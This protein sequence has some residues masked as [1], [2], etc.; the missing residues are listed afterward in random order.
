[1][2]CWMDTLGGGDEGQTGWK[3]RRDR[4]G[5]TAR[6]GV[7]AWLRYAQVK[8]GVLAHPAR[9]QC[10]CFSLVG[11]IALTSCVAFPRT[12]FWGMKVPRPDS[13]AM[14]AMMAMARGSDDSSFM[15]RR[16]ATCTALDCTKVLGLATPPPSP[17]PEV[18][19]A[20]SMAEGASVGRGALSTSSVGGVFPRRSL[21]VTLSFFLSPGCPP[22]FWVQ[23]SRLQLNI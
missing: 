12:L 5:G 16:H 7:G 1:M 3:S 18:L 22:M 23:Q 13:T 14:R 8:A 19:G 15:S 6:E 9:L 2:D 17:R 21:S 11:R 4:E 10:K 20:S